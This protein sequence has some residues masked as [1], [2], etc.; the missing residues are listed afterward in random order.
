MNICFSR[1]KLNEIFKTSPATPDRLNSRENS[2]L[3]FKEGFSFGHLTDYAK[4]CAA[5]ANTKGGY[6]IFGIT[7][8]PRKLAGLKPK[9]I[10]AFEKIDPEMISGFFNEHFAPEIKWE[11][12]VHEIE[13]KQ[14][15]LLYIF[16]SGTKP[17]ICSKETQ[18]A[19]IREGDIYYRYRGRTSRIKY[20]ELRAML[21]ARLKE[22]QRLWVRHLAKIARIGVRDA[23]I[24]D[25]Q[26]GQMSGTSGSLLI[27]E[28]LLSQLSF[29]KEGEFS[30]SKGKP[31]LKLIGEVSSVNGAILPDRK[32]IIKSKG[33]RVSDIVLSFLDMQKTPEA[34]E[35]IKQICF[36]TTAFLP[37]Y[38][39]LSL[40]KLKTED[41]IK[42]INGMVCRSQAKN[43]LI[44]RLQGKET[45]AIEISAT[46][47]NSVRN[48]KLFIEALRKKNVQINMSEKELVECLQAIRM[49][50]VS[51]VKKMSEY[52]RKFLKNVFN[53]YYSSGSG[54]VAGNIRRSICW[55]DEALYK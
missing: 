1:T 51:E 18:G 10:E 38:Y 29:I 23:G 12:H 34:L 32:Q 8:N 44:E 16:E 26:T 28:A 47:T 52:L 50:S 55:I 15:G 7:N 3:E 14:F 39:Y 17:V 31:T 54:S 21:D 48:K 41:V 30:E 49:L 11:M 25:F 53:R 45:Q 36:E 37:V 5:F 46:E 35:H 6:L 42:I 27:D 40:A 19:T 4:T 43:K 20:A 24:F 13:G 33:I 22:E 2:E 9:A